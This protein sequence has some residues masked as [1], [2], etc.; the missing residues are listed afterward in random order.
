[1]QTVVRMRK[2]DELGR[3]VLPTEARAYLNL[4]KNDTVKVCC[5]DDGVT[6]QKVDSTEQSENVLMRKIDKL[7][8]I[9]LPIEARE[10]KGLKPRDNVKVSCNS[11]II[12]IQYSESCDPTGQEYARKT[13]EL[14]RVIIPRE[15]REH[16][17]LQSRD[18]LNFST[19]GDVITVTKSRCAGKTPKTKAP[20]AKVPKRETFSTLDELGRISLKQDIRETL[21]IQPTDAVIIRLISDG[22]TLSKYSKS[23][24]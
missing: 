19:N 21:D 17:G 20:K 14:S 2:I 16:L 13:D 24:N 9:L 12:T 4:Q 22:F 18:Q 5:T 7:G 8:R 3:V 1:M 11:D 23:V 10:Q 15:I 6:L